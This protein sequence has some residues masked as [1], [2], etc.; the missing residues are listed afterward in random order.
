MTVVFLSMKAPSISGFIIAGSTG[1]VAATMTMPRMPRANTRQYG[2][3][4]ASSRR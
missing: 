1:S 2:L 3:T 4:Y